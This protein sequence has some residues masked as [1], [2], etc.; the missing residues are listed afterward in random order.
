ML[1]KKRGLEKAVISSLLYVIAAIL[2]G[3]GSTSMLLGISVVYVVL[4]Y[5]LLSKLAKKELLLHTIVSIALRV[6]LAFVLYKG[7]IFYRIYTSVYAEKPAPG[8]GVG[9]VISLC[10]NMILYLALITIVVIKLCS[11]GRREREK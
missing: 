2:T 7:D 9:I 5:V 4:E 11:T 3:L 1:N 6:L 10:L 8:T